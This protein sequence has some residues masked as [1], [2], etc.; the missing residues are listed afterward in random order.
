MTISNNFYDSWKLPNCLGAIDENHVVMEKPSHSGSLYY[1]YKS[2]FSIILLATC[3]AEYN[4][5]TINVGGYGKQ[6]DGSIFAGST[7]GKKLMDGSLKICGPRKLP[8]TLDKIMPCYFVGD[9][10]F[11]LTTY[12]IRPYPG[13]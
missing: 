1:N 3:D 8:N 9:E 12:M 10:A 7:L 2:T 11:P 5:T 13:K 4:F 6:R